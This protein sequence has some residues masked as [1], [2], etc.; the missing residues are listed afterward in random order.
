MAK[1]LGDWAAI[2]SLVNCRDQSGCDPYGRFQSYGNVWKLLLPLGFQD[3]SILLLVIATA[4]IFFEFS[5]LA[6]KIRVPLMPVALLLSP[7]FVFVFERGNADLFL[8]ALALLGIRILGKHKIFSAILAVLLTSLKPFFLGYLIVINQKFY[9]SLFL[10]PLCLLGYFASMNFD[11][12]W[13]RQARSVNIFMPNL[14]FGADQLPASVYQ[15]LLN[16]LHTQNLGWQPM[17]SKIFWFSSVTSS[18]LVA[19]S[20]L[21]R[22]NKLITNLHSEITVLPDHSKNIIYASMAIF[23]STYISGSQVTYKTW[24]ISPFV[25]F[26]VSYFRHSGKEARWH[27]VVLIPLL[28]FAT[29]GVNLWIVRNIGC[30]LIAILCISILLRELLIGFLTR[31]QNIL[32]KPKI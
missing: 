17:P 15:Y 16:I 5:L 20:I 9:K 29:F 10:V 8:Y 1:G 30:L 28:L 7:T 14:A 12:N 11:L 4:Y 21:L 25:I 24:F 32:T 27:L 3:F 6:N 23:C 31:N 13:I 19:C 18:F 2:P 26:L 22:K